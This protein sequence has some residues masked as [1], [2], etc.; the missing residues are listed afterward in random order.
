MY[1]IYHHFSTDNPNPKECG[2]VIKKQENNKTIIEYH[3]SKLAENDY[4]D[5]PRINIFHD[6]DV[7]KRLYFDL[8]P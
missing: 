6:Y 2:Y 4:K 8:E 7:E 5:V 1:D 3:L